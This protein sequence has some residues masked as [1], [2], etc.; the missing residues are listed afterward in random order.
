MSI[1]LQDSPNCFPHFHSTLLPLSHFPPPPTPLLAILCDS[2]SV[3]L[4]QLNAAEAA[5]PKPDNLEIFLINLGP[6]S[7]TSP[8]LQFVI[9]DP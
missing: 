3:C 2:F 4:F 1:I 5:T 6:V 7:P 9:V 8:P